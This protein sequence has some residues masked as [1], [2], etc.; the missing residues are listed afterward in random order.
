MT[1]VG[2]GLIVIASGPVTLFCGELES[3]AFTVTIV[4]PA[5]VGVPLTRQFAPR[6]NPAGSS[7]AVIVQ[8]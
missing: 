4:V 5:V 7:F 6:A 8:L 1:S 2:D 3:V